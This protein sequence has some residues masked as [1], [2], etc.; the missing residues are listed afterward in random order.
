VLLAVFI[1]TIVFEFKDVTPFQRGFYCND[2]SIKYPYRSNTVPVWIVCVV[3]ILIPVFTV[4]EI[5]LTPYSSDDN[6]GHLRLE[7]FRILCL[8]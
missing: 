6:D 3:G 1:P 5:F 4:S 2:D 7:K 8:Q